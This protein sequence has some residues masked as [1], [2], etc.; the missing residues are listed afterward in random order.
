MANVFARQ[1]EVADFYVSPNGND[2]FSG[3][4]PQTN[5]GGTDG[6]FRTLQ[7][8][9]DAVRERIKANTNDMVVM[10]RGG[11]YVLTEAVT[12]SLSDAG[13]DGQRIIYRNYPEEEPVL[14]PAVAITGWEKAP[15]D[16]PGLPEVAKGKAWTVKL[17]P[18]IKPFKAL[19][20]DD[21][22]LTRAVSKGY[23]A[24]G[25]WKDPT[26]SNSKLYYPPG[27][28]LK[29]WDNIG[30]IDL[31][32]RPTFEFA[33]SILQLAHV[34]EEARIA[35]V[36]IPSRW[37]LARLWTQTPGDVDNLWIENTI[38]VLDQPGEWV[39][40]TKQNRLYLWP[41]D[42]QK[43]GNILAPQLTELVKV[44]GHIDYD[45]ATD[46]PVRNIT[47][48]GLTF[49][50]ADRYTWPDDH[51]G[52]DLQEKWEIFDRPSAM[53]RLRGAA[54]CVIERCRFVDSASAGIR[55]DLYCQDN[56]IHNNLFARIG[57]VGALLAGYGPGTKDVNKENRVTDNYFHDVGQVYW[58]SPAIYLWQSGEN[59]VTHNLIS[60][61][62]YSGIIIS[63]W[64][65]W[66]RSGVGMSTKTIRWA[67][68]EKT[69]DINDPDLN[70]LDY[71]TWAKRRPF[72]H[73]K[74]NI[75]EK[76]EIRRFTQKLGDG[77]AVYL[78]GAGPQNLIRL[79]YV[80]DCISPTAREGIRCD[81]GQYETII[82]K[83]VVYKTGG[84]AFGIAIKGPN[85]IV[86]NIIAGLVTGDPGFDS[87]Y[88]SLQVYPPTGSFIQRNII[89]SEDKNQRACGT[90][91]AWYLKQPPPEWKT[92]NADYNIYFNTQDPAWLDQHFAEVRPSGVE[93][94]S[95]FADPL[96]SDLENEN[97]L[98]KPESPALKLGFEQ[99]DI[100][101]AGL[102]RDFPKEFLK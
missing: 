90:L 30:D 72:L 86:N 54:N 29:N 39:L 75:V 1:T 3:T 71:K 5:S 67:E 8:A 9:R 24:L 64:V 56:T 51:A 18:G 62:P 22:R 41:L 95:L 15:D 94:H 101:E 76:N 97:F 45:G 69:L 26:A 87:H 14:T 43:P 17:A 11:R 100:T 82:E 28:M 34:D 12:F 79:N 80:H 89:Y 23:S 92:T 77:N 46:V 13:K 84:T 78:G 40:N 7:R 98:L 25:D 99:I 88:L 81:D 16:T 21:R 68:V 60:D 52:W 85:T 10:L 44:E 38:E 53:V 96:F 70:L 32:M 93:I 83:N 27:V 48:Q 50:A 19:Y 73:A 66:L 42:G 57:G 35:T 58:N 59:L 91:S 65:D 31:L 33:M 102:T 61:T 47:F 20:Q 37:P 4:L 63:G 36:A 49:T 74:R 2:G 6:P 55:L